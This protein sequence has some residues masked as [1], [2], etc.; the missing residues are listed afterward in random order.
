MDFTV[1]FF[2]YTSITEVSRVQHPV[3]QPLY[4]YITNT[5]QWL[6]QY[7]QLSL[8]HLNVFTQ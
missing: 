5:Q 8:G 1:F 2:K 4:M 7:Q 3:G 6:E